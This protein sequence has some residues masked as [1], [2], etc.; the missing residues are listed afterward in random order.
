MKK[1]GWIAKGYLL[2]GLL[3]AGM[4]SHAVAQDGRQIVL[5]GN[6]AQLT[7]GGLGRAG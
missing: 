6:A 7:A 4:V 5:K 3:I 1:T 2:C